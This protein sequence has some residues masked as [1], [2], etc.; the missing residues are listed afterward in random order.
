MDGYIPRYLSGRESTLPLPCL[1][2]NSGGPSNLTI[3]GGFPSA[4]AKGKNGLAGRYLSSTQSPTNFPCTGVDFCFGV[5]R[6]P[7]TKP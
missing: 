6:L 1:T 7:S 2:D 4:K 5:Y 3:Q